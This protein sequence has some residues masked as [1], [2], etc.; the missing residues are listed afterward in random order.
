MTMSDEE[1]SLTDLDSTVRTIVALWSQLRDWQRVGVADMNRDLRDA[2]DTLAEHVERGEGP[3]PTEAPREY[4]AE[5]RVKDLEQALKAQHRRDN[6]LHHARKGWAGEVDGGADRYARDVTTVA[7][8]FD[9]FL[10]DGAVHEVPTA[11]E[12]TDPDPAEEPAVTS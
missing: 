6:A 4:P 10:A 3:P 12:V 11:T 9:R 5:M 2:L 7:Q 1:L 8:V